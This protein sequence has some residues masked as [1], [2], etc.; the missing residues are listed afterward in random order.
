MKK[1]LA[2]SLA[3][4]MTLILLMS[5]QSNQQQQSPAPDSPIRIATLAGPTGMGIVRL[6]DNDAYE[7]SIYS[8]PDQITPKVISGEVDAATIPSNVAAVLYNKMNGG[9]KIVAINT[10]GVLYIL[11]NGD[12][13]NSIDDLS[14]KTLY[15]T[16]QGATPEYALEKILAH[17]GVSDTDVKY[18]GAH[19]DLANAMAAGDVALALLPEPFVSTVLSKNPAVTVKID[20]N[21][22]WQK[23]YGEEAGMPMGVTIVSSEFAENKAAMERL[24]AD[25][26][27]SVLYVTDKTSNAA[28]DI[29]AEKIV[30][31][32][33]IAK[34]AIPRSGIS[35]II[36]PSC[37]KILD[38]YFAL[39]YESNPDSLGGSVP[40]E[41]IFFMPQN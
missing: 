16:G 9:I 8:T 29:A 30:G 26:S 15:A 28:A 4:A 10:T 1:I 27:A 35:F 38:D 23:I 21:D 18:M 20:I 19:A 6:M 36:G 41:D 33:D 7:I 5:C 32:E 11:E 39:M 3:L 13:V 40:A 24:I 31:S 2:V 25:Y 22:E 37:K 17:N 12:T 34:A 14:G